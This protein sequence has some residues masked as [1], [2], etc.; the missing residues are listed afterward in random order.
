MLTNTQ[1]QLN[2]GLHAHQYPGCSFFFAAKAQQV[3]WREQW[4]TAQDLKG[5]KFRVYYDKLAI[6]TGS[7]VRAH[8]NA[9]SHP[10]ACR[11]FSSIVND[12]TGPT[13]KPPEGITL[14][15]CQ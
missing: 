13:W 12:G 4:V 10:P 9:C 6:C 5:H 2:A 8:Q 7:Q 11:C 14:C 1:V 3:D 15:P